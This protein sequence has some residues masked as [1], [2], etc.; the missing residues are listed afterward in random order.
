MLPISTR[1]VK[2]VSDSEPSAIVVLRGLLDSKG[3]WETPTT[4]SESEAVSWRM[5]F[6]FL[7]NCTWSLSI[8][9]LHM[10]LTHAL[11]EVQP[12]DMNSIIDVS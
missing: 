4:Q 5:E 6:G 9:G 1:E 8:C 12:F 7:R 10:P 3:G 11:K 2:D